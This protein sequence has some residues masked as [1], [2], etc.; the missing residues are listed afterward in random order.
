MLG[1]M[2]NWSSR[3]SD[4]RR[5]GMTVAEIGDAIGLAQ[6]S[7]SDIESGRSKEPRGDAAVALH[8]LHKS[9]VDESLGEG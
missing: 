8:E 4:L 1:S 2:S 3:I 6:S 7:V 9:K 5:K